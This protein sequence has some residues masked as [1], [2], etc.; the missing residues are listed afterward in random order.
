M[1]TSTHTKGTG[2][3]LITDIYIPP[4]LRGDDK[5]ARDF[6]DNDLTPSIKQHGLIHPVVIFYDPDHA[7]RPTLIAGWS[8]IQAFKNLGLTSIPYVERNALSRDEALSLE[9]EENFR[10]NK[11]KWQHATLGIF[12][13]HELKKKLAAGDLQEWGMAQTGHLLGVAMSKVSNACLVAKELIKQNKAVTDAPSFQEAVR[14]ILKAKSDEAAAQLA[15]VSGGIAAAVAKKPRASGPIGADVT[16][17]LMPLASNVEGLMELPANAERPKSTL[18]QNVVPLSKMLFNAD[19]HDWLAQCLPES[20]DGV[21]TDIP[22]GIDMDPLEGVQ[23]IELV[24]D[25]HDI[26]E[27]VAQMKPFLAA[28]YRVLKPDT[29]AFLWYDIKHQEKL[30][31][32][33]EEAGFTPQPFPN[34]WIKTHTCRNRAAHCNW[35]KSI[36]YVLVLKKGKPTL[37]TPQL[38]NYL[39][40]SGEAE[41]KM[42][43]NPFAKPFE[44]SKWLLEPVVLPGQTWLDPYAGGGSLI[45]AMIN[46]G[47]RPI[48]IE[49]DPKQFPLLL[50]SIQNLYRSALR[51]VVFE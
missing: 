41:R 51:N 5:D 22:Y 46:L 26:D 2:E 38:K 43:R 27:N 40:C 14:I 42:Q 15:R 7:N 17:D 33:A 32:W 30:M 11:M 28:I 48:G 49:K 37:K 16:T 29:Y 36:E 44:F 4:R 1:S 45:R 39:P 47:L 34:V 21:Y 8:R 6:I 9:L 12:Q 19:C 25:A 18:E 31:T 13:T 24:K 3:L 20:V 35:T 50:D 23:D 10:R